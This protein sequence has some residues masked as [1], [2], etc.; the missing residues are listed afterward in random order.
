MNNKDNVVILGCSIMSLYMGIKL[1][2]IGYDVSIIEKRRSDTPVSVSSYNNCNIFKESHTLYINILKK[3][4]IQY[5]RIEKLKNNEIFNGFINLLL[6][7]SRYV[8]DYVLVSH[9]VASLCSYLRISKEYEVFFKNFKGCS[10]ISKEMNSFDFVN[11]FK[12]DFSQ[13]SKFYFVNNI[14]LD[15]LL[16]KMITDFVNKKGNIIFNTEVVNVK[17]LQKKF[18]LGTNMQYDIKS[19]MLILCI[20]Q[21]NIKK[22]LHWNKEQLRFLDSVKPVYLN[23]V[24]D[25]L[26]KYLT[27]R[28]TESTVNKHIKNTLLNTFHI[29]HPVDEKKKP[30]TFYVWKPGVN[31]LHCMEKIKKLYNNKFIIC[32]D[33]FSKNNM[34]IYYS[35][36]CV[37]DVLHSIFNQM[38]QT[39]LYSSY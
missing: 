12:S 34:F 15:N 32:S 21:K 37:E 18:N 1:K 4:S 31:K 2:D 16:Y 22:F 13:V 8:P 35:L 3:Y 23:I 28:N 19:N 33:S 20:S 26:C 9:N 10:S 6:Q 17:Y 39:P 25:W 14:S 36:L 7:R 29:V 30:T 24:Y 27:I 38:N 11:I 5:E